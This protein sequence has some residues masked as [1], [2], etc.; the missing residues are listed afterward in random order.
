MYITVLKNTYIQ[1]TDKITVADMVRDCETRRRDDNTQY[2]V[3]HLPT[4]M[5]YQSLLHRHLAV[6]MRSDVKWRGMNEDE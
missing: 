3:T 4:H 1:Y 5:W 2:T 6:L